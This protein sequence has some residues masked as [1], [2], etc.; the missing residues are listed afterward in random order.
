MEISLLREDTSILQIPAQHLITVQVQIPVFVPTPWK[1]L[2]HTQSVPL[3]TCLFLWK[4]LHNAVPVCD[5]LHSRIS[6][7]SPICP[8]C[9]QEP[10]TVTHLLFRCSHAR[11]TWFQSPLGLRT[12]NISG[13]DISLIFTRIWQQLDKS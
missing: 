13:S 4:V 12:E 5:V 7:I 2:W 9:D 1:T 11:A 3:R 6:H 10:E 8:L